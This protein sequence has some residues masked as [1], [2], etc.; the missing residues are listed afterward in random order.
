MGFAIF[1]KTVPKVSH[2][3]H[4]DIPTEAPQNTPCLS[5]TVAMPTRQSPVKFKLSTKTWEKPTKKAEEYGKGWAFYQQSLKKGC[6]SSPTISD[7]TFQQHP[8]RLLTSNHTRFSQYITFRTHHRHHSDTLFQSLTYSHYYQLGF[9]ALSQTHHY[10]PLCDW[11]RQMQRATGC[12]HHS[13]Q[14]RS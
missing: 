1:P 14:I 12:F 3:H 10:F 6:L 11:M 13:L 9:L 4:T 2:R 8:H 7:S 5:T